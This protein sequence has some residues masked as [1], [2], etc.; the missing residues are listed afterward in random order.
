[1]LWIMAHIHCEYL[2]LPKKQLVYANLYD[3]NAYNKLTTRTHF[4]SN[5]RV[6]YMR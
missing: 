1:M 6:G 4:Y 5:V 2:H 3:S